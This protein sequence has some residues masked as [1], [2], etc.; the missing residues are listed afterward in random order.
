[1]ELFDKYKVRD[2]VKHIFTM[3]DQY[4]TTFH[5]VIS[6]YPTLLI[7]DKKGVVRFVKVGVN[8]N[9]DISN[10]EDVFETLKKEILKIL[11]EDK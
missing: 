7:I 5:N 11:N 4:E 8:Y 2:R 6:A 3:G 1:M 10:T 9:N